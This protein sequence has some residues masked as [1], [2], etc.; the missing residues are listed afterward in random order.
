MTRCTPKG[1]GDR[2]QS[3]EARGGSGGVVES[4][5]QLFPGCDNVPE[6]VPV[7]LCCLCDQHGVSVG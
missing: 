7:S 1:S 6:P 5:L 2:K 4:I 3:T